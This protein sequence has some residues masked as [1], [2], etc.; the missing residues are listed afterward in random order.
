MRSQRRKDRLR[1]L[2]GGSVDLETVPQ[3]SCSQD[4]VVCLD[5]DCKCSPRC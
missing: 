3:L 2:M 1:R 4:G 5:N